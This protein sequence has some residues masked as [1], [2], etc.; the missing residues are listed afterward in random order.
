MSRDSV[1]INIQ[2]NVNTVGATGSIVSLVPPINPFT[3]TLA[4]PAPK[5]I[6]TCDECHNKIKPQISDKCCS[7]CKQQIVPKIDKILNKIR[8]NC[9]N[10]SIYHNRRYHTYKNILFSVFRVPLIIL[11]GGN[12]F[13]AVGMQ[14]YLSQNTISIVNALLSILCGVITSIEL[15]L[16]LQKRMELELESYKNYY[17]LSIEIYRFIK[18]DVADRE[19]ESKEFLPKIYETYEELIT[20]SNAVNVYRRGF[21]DEFD[22]VNDDI[23]VTEIP[24]TWHTYFCHC[25]Y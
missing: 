6:P 8:H 20:H 9:V 19:A 3:L 5:P 16:N 7:T 2:E 15:L 24:N 1:A 10:L 18:L 23:V 25:C 4:K 12:S 13:I 17:K 21:I 22:D 14:N 11:A